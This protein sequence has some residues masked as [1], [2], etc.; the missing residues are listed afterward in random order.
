MVPRCWV[1]SALHVQ[2]IVASPMLCV[3]GFAY[4]QGKYNVACEGTA[5]LGR[6]VGKP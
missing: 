5:K 2:F 1:C 3:A 4:K 6:V